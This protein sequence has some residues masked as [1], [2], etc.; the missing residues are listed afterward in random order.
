M[1][2]DAF[3]IFYKVLQQISRS[4]ND[5]FY[6]FKIHNLLNFKEIFLVVTCFFLDINKSARIKKLK[7]T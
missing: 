5:H 3:C 7:A 1:I 6:G 4:R 2:Q